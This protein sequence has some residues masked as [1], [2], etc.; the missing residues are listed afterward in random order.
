MKEARMEANLM[1][2]V[3][4][5][6]EK[7][8]AKLIKLGAN[9]HAKDVAGYT[10]LHHCLT[11]SSNPTTWSMAKQLLEAGANPN[12]QNRFGSTPLFFPVNAANLENV[13]LLLKYGADPDIKDWDGI[14]CRLH[15]RFSKV[16][17]DID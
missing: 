3:Q 12:T 6:H 1:K 9:I 10:P 15:G 2:K 7:I 11:F 8:L 17:I 4:N 14:D 5:D 16:S 13:G